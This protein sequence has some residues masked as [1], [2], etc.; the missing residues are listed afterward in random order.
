MFDEDGEPTR[1]IDGYAKV[2]KTYDARGNVV[3]EA[4]FDEKGDPTRSKDGVMR[5]SPKPTIPM[6]R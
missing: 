4:Y 2:T 6:G 1:S 3:Q 5:R